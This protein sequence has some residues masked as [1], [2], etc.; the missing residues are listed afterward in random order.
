MNMHTN[1]QVALWAILFFSALWPTANPLLAADASRETGKQMVDNK[2]RHFTLLTEPAEA[3]VEILNLKTP[4][5]PNMLLKPGRY[6]MVVSAPGYE[7]EKG[8]IDILDQDWIGKVVLHPLNAPAAQ[9][10]EGD[11]PKQAMARLEEEMRKIK[12]EQANLEQT[13]RSLA[14]EQEKL[15]ATKKELEQVKQTAEDGKQTVE[16]VKKEQ[17][18][19][20]QAKRDLEQ[21]KLEQSRKDQ[22]TLESTRKELE[23]ARKD[24]GTLE[25]TRKEL[26]QAR[27]D[28]GTLE[29]TRKELEQVRRELQ[30]AKKEL[31]EKQQVAC[32]AP[33]ESKMVTEGKPATDSAPVTDKPVAESRPVPPVPTP[34]PH[35]KVKEK[36]SPVAEEPILQPVVTEE[37]PPVA[38]AA[39]EQSTAATE[40]AAPAATEAVEPRLEGMAK[41]KLA[42]ILAD[43]QQYLQLPRPP[44]SDPPPESDG[45]LRRLRQAQKADPG[46]PAIA[47]AL[48]LHAKRY[49][50]YTGLF[51]HK[52]RAD[53]MVQRIQELGIAAFQQAMVVKGKPVQRICIGP[54]LTQEEAD[55][56]L[57]HLQANIEV[58]DVILRIYKQ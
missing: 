19:L 49:I 48:Q 23:Q 20:E 35:A 51:E 5:Q 12:Q 18:A 56:N 8:F 58:K 14:Q 55:K 24:Q 1:K 22:G 10:E 50:A 37:S 11:D 41:G 54:F 4:Y 47:Q 42:A 28:Q 32:P 25:S 46:N 7:T 27:K 30:L 44:R 3:K 34:T 2:P 13:R 29:S 40:P 17:S 21:A 33:V 16:Q 15:E 57:R 26:E 36:S 38:E 9:T 53:A 39:P 52:D 6:H 45:I 31:S 43:A